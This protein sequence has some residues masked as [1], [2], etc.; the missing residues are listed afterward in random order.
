MQIGFSIPPLKC[1]K[2]IPKFWSTYIWL[3]KFRIALSDFIL[4]KYTNFSTLRFKKYFG[5]DF[6]TI[7]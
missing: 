6:D 2:I 4:K 7:L 1:T 3:H 5:A